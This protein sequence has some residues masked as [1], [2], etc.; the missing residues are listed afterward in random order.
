MDLIS[1][2]VPIYNVEKYLKKCVYSLINQ[3]YKNIEILLID[4]GSTDTCPSICD[5]IE[6]EDTRVR[7]IHQKNMGLSGARN[8]GIKKAIGHYIMF[9]D[10]DDS[11]ELECVETLYNL[12][13]K[14]GT[15]ISVCG[16]YYEFEDGS[17]KCKYSEIFNKKYD[18][19]SAIEEMNIFYYFDMSAWG[20]LYKKELF[21][22]IEFPVGKL[23]EDYFVMYKLFKMAG[24]ISYTSKP[25]YNYLQRQNSISKSKKINFDFIEAAKCQMVDLENYSERLKVITHVAYASSCLTIV[26][27]YI[28]QSVKCPKE[29][30]IQYRNIIK[31]NLKYIASY[32]K[33]QFYLFLCNFYLYKICFIAYRRKK[34]I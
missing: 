6:K 7:V 30:I 32:K 1:I 29:K 8:T 25:L 2:V 24:T 5:E 27:F 19:E 4:D 31:D 23:S 14:E 28:K 17:K 13:L 22:N 18:F 26:D 20:K 12:I 34:I 16:R 3:T 10:S 21:N 9:V 11:V 15:S 33:V